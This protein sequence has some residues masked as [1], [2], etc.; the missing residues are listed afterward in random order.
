VPSQERIFD[1]GLL[2][3]EG[4]RR[5]FINNAGFGRT[6]EA[7]RRKKSNPIR[8]IFSLTEKDV[9]L[10]WGEGG[11]EARESEYFLLG[12]VCNAPYFNGGLHYSKE[13]SPDD[14]LLDGYFELPQSRWK[15]LYKFI[16]G[17]RGRPLTSSKTF[18]LRSSRIRVSSEQE[19]FPQVD[20]EPASL[21]GIR[22]LEFSVRPQAV[23]FIF[24]GVPT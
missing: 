20:G 21:R 15:L 1:V 9:E 7:L 24:D 16:Q 10:D 17:R 3:G 22:S 13:C 5:T 2:E 12:V 4:V 8:D 18:S 23:K 6:K 19:L 11:N 14:G